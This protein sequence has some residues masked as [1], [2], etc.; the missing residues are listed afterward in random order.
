MN[1][2][3]ILIVDDDQDDQVFLQE[4]WKELPYANKKLFSLALRKK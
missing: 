2:G 1:N 4:A 3:P